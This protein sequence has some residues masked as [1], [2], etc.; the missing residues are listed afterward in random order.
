[1]LILVINL[2]RRPDRLAFMLSQLDALELAF[3][4]VEA[5]DGRQDNVGSGTDLITPVEIACALSH[6]KAWQRFLATDAPLCLILEDDVLIAP[7]A[8]HLLNAPHDLPRDADIV[9][10]ETTLQRT[11]L[12][13]G[14]RCG[15]T[16]HR[17]HRFH[18]QQRGT[19][20]YIVTRRFAEHA[21]RHFTT[22]T[23]PIDDILTVVSSPNY[24]P[25]ISYQIVPGL[26]IQADLYEPAQKTALAASD[27]DADRKFRF[28]GPEPVSEVKVKRSIPE[29]CVREVG[30]WGRRGKTMVDAF[31]ER[32]IVRRVWRDV[33]FIGTILPVAATVLAST[34]ETPR[35]T[36]LPRRTAPAD[37]DHQAANRL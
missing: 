21:V 6:R 24:L 5:I 23:D 15:L 4:R 7:E 28:V 37:L 32:I 33:P 34:P 10:L 29:K 2:T 19:A 16:G 1:M 13:P 30:R 11:L 22:P 20:A 26:C 27:L 3:E 9:R 25:N 35:P 18:S 12:G 31:Y 17:A 8:K 14:M 36:A